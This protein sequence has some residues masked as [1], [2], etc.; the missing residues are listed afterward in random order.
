MARTIWIPVLAG[1]LTLIAGSRV[2][3][4]LAPLQQSA[5]PSAADGLTS[6]SIQ[7]ELAGDHTKALQLADDA[8]KSDGKNPWAR[9]AKGDA[10]G[11]SQR[12][13]D[14]AS[15]YRE[16]EQHFT[17]GE[18][19]GKSIAMW[20]EANAFFQ[21]GRCQDSSPLYERY[22]SFV[23]KVDP[24]AAALARKFEKSCVTHPATH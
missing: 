9:Y 7:T 20:G 5:A 6:Q 10:L 22:A 23:E 8:I 17:A 3:A 24:A 16:A 18:M 12:P 4:Q 15:A 11:S 2:N 1:A 19:W 13:D 14:A 21:V